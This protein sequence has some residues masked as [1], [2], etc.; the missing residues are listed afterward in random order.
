MKQLTPKRLSAWLLTL[1]MLMGMLPAMASADEVDEDLSPPAPQEDYG[2]VRLVFDEGGQLDL[3]HGEYITECSPTAA[4]HD[5]ADEDFLTDGDYL[6]LYYEGRL[7]HKA[8]L[9]G[10]RIDADAVL[11][12][13]DFALVPMGEL[14]AQAPLLGAE[15]AALTVEGTNE[16]TAEGSN[17]QQEILPPLAPPAMKAPLRAAATED[18][19]MLVIMEDGTEIK[20]FPGKAIFRNNSNGASD[21][22]SGKTYVAE[23][24]RTDQDQYTSYGKWTLI[25]KSFH[26]QSITYVKGK[27]GATGYYIDIKLYGDSVLTAG[28]G[29][30]TDYQKNYRGLSCGSATEGNDPIGNAIG[31]RIQSAYDDSDASLTIRADYKTARFMNYAQGIFAS[32]L[33]IG[34]RATVRIDVAVPESNESSAIHAGNVYLKDNSSLDIKCSNA[35]QAVQVYSSGHG[36]HVLDI[37]TA[38]SVNIRMQNQDRL[39]YS[40]AFMGAPGATNSF[41]M[42]RVGYMRIVTEGSYNSS[43]AGEKYDFDAYPSWKSVDEGLTKVTFAGNG[44]HQI[45]YI[46]GAT[47]DAVQ[48]YVC[49]GRIKDG[50]YTFYNQL[51]RALTDGTADITITAPESNIP[52]K[53]WVALSANSSTE[54]RSISYLA[55]GSKSTD[56]TV[57]LHF[58]GAGTRRILAK[59]DPFTTKP[60]CTYDYSPAANCPTGKISWAAGYG[61][62]NATGRLIDEYYTLSS[63]GPTAATDA[64]GNP[65]N[66][67]TSGVSV[68]APQAGSGINYVLPSG[69]WYRIAL[70]DGSGRWHISDSFRIDYPTTAAPPAPELVSLNCSGEETPLSPSATECYPFARGLIVKA[71]NFDYDQYE[72]YYTFNNGGDDPGDPVG[73][74]PNAN[75]GVIV[76]KD[77]ETWL[78][79]TNLRVRFKSKATGAWSPTTKVPLQKV[80]NDDIGLYCSVTFAPEENYT[81]KGFTLTI[82]DPITATVTKDHPD[83]WPINAELV[84]NTNRVALGS[85]YTNYT[86]ETVISFDPDT[87]A[88][89]GYD[90]AYLQVGVRVPDPKSSSNDYAILGGSTS[91]TIKLP[92]ANKL[93]LEN[94]TATVDGKTVAS[95]TK[96]EV[97][98]QVKLTLNI[99][100]GYTFKGWYSTMGDDLTITPLADGTYYFYMPDQDITVRPI[101]YANEYTSMTVIF[102][103]YSGSS[104]V[105]NMSDI[106]HTV[107]DVDGATTG[108]TFY[109]GNT[110]YN[111]ALDK[112]S[113]CYRAHITCS[114]AENAIFSDNM[115]LRANCKPNSPY[116]QLLKG[117][118]T[119][120]ADKKTLEFDVWLVFAPEVT[121]PLYEGESKPTAEQCTTQPGIKVTSLTWSGNTIQEMKIKDEYLV[122]DSCSL[123]RLAA[124][125]KVWINGVLYDATYDYEDAYALTVKNTTIPT[126][127]K[128]VT[129]SGTVKSYNPNNAVTIQLMQGGEEKYSTTI[130]A[131]TGSGQVTQNFSFPTV[132]A[133]TYDLVVTKPGHLTYTVKNVVVEND[134]LDLTKHSNAA[135]STITLLCGDIDGNGFINS[136]DLGIILKG[137]NYGKSTATA[138]DKA[139]DLDGNGFINSTDLGIV[140]QG[141]HYG[142]SAVSVGFAG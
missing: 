130:A 57:T 40:F 118:F 46:P 125:P 137:Q 92:D 109:K 127:S 3:H 10:V 60:T 4:V 19:H 72:M 1:I 135:I 42:N 62:E 126:V 96:V 61:L 113:G 21:P 73:T 140:L 15:P 139:A 25:L 77:S 78:G 20:L 142:K 70:Q 64:S 28:A 136:T 9:D 49:D 17:E 16:E 32:D 134:P 123:F 63:D 11:P 66:K 38:G 53:K 48:L 106:R 120:S 26:A 119:L 35:R 13:E 111:G 41:N 91:Y 39:N 90:A 44:F 100:E 45:Q 112:D 116:G 98:K 80:P 27:G 85:T 22:I 43:A 89:S 69:K 67:V 34:K 74:S 122:G 132:A 52:F 107:S 56:E 12:A 79:V 55:T 87:I 6:A 114:A 75:N 76:L 51:Y 117:G 129:V 5:G 93:W 31:F 65:I 7:Y 104:V 59:Y 58:D 133:G 50:R 138:G 103:V 47:A 24:Q 81:L 102:D 29:S 128:G 2:Y 108:I 97:G 105:S 95:N 110:P 71:T 18:A 37:D 54:E 131:D 82:T 88:A 23:L 101:L 33:Y 124:N 86:E 83:K 14:A 94:C 99:P 30:V 84:Y 8:T 36:V 141:Q 121:V 68:F 115:K